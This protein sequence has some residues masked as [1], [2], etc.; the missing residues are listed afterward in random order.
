MYL[1]WLVV[2]YHIGFKPKWNKLIKGLP[3]M[4]EAICI[5]LEYATS[6]RWPLAKEWVIWRLRSMTCAQIIL[7]KYWPDMEAM[8]LK[9]LVNADIKQR[10]I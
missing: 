10:Q 5:D 8:L 6:G 7:A 9:Y 2:Y 4:L 3:E 1:R